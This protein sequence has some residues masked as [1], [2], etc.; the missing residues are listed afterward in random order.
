M[1][2]LSN[3]RLLALWEQA[4]DE[5][6]LD[7]ALTL[8]AALDPGASRAA[9]ADLPLAERDR[10]L[11]AITATVAGDRISVLARCEACE[12]DTELSF[13]AAAIGATEE[14]RRPSLVFDGEEVPYRLPC[15]RDVAQALRAATPEEARL[16]LLGSL[17]DHPA[18]PPALLDA[19][20]TKLAERAGIEALTL[21]HSCA[22]CGAEAETPFDILD[23][24]WRHVAARAQRLMRDIHLLASAYGWTSEEILSLSD[25]RRAAHIAMVVG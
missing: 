9:L 5:H 6:P 11:F 14:A 10:L 7:R 12:T 24:L 21:R 16:A 22:A 8:I 20:D 17:I 3:T 23:Y 25:R 15:S 18:P 4:A 2:G 1:H 13:S 19:L